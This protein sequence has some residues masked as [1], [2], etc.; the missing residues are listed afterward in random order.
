MAGDD[1]DMPST[2]ILLNNVGFSLGELPLVICIQPDAHT[3]IYV[4]RVSIPR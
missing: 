1:L 2:S 3:I 4:V